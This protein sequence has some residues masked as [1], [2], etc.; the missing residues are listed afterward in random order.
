MPNDHA[1]YSRVSVSI[2]RSIPAGLLG[3]LDDG[4]RA[5][6]RNREIAWG[7]PLLVEDHIGQTREAVVVGYN[8]AYDQLELSLRLVEH[9]PWLDVAS[10]YQEN[11]QV[12]G[13]VVGLT[14]AGAFVELEPGIEGFLPA[15]ELPLEPPV[16][17]EDWLWIHDRLVALITELDADR[18]R[19]RLSLRR[20]LRRREAQ[21]HRQMWGGYPQVATVDVTVA[22]VLPPQVRQQ[23]LRLAPAREPLDLEPRVE[24]LLIEDDADYAAGLE[25]FLQGNGCHVTVTP[26]AMSGL[27]HV[28]SQA[29]P[30]DLI[31]VDWNLPGLKGHQVIQQLQQLGCA[32]RL[33]MVLEPAPLREYPEIR[34][35]LWQSGVDVFSKADGE[36]CRLG[37]ITILRELRRQE[38]D[39]R[40]SRQRS[41]PAMM[42]PTLDQP[43][44]LAGNEEQALPDRRTD[45]Q[46]I[47][48]A[49]LEDT[50]ATTALLL[51]L[52]P[53]HA[54][55]VLESSAGVAFPL[56]QA[57]PDLIYS[58]LN[59]VLHKGAEVWE[60]VPS[61][62]AKFK[63]LL[64]LLPFQGFLGIPLP[65]VH[66]ARHGLVL[67]K[68][69]GSFGRHHRQRARVAVYLLA[70][71]L[72]EQRLTRAL[73]P[74]QAQ[75]L[76]GQLLNSMIHEVTNKLG[77]LEYQTGILREGLRDLA[78]WPQKAQ[79]PTFLRTLEQ[80]AE[81]IADGQGRAGEL[82]NRYLGLT[83][84]DEPQSVDL[85][86]LVGE[87]IDVM[88]PEAQQHNI[89]LGLEAC[90]DLPPVWARPS[91]L[92]QI[93]LNLLLNAIQQMAALQRQGNLIV[94]LAYHPDGSLPLKVRF[95]DEGCGIHH[96]L[97]E[98]IFDF[99]FTTKKDGAGLGLTISRQAAA[100]LGGRLQVEESHVL[101]GT[102]FLLEL[103]ETATAAS[104]GPG[105]E[106]RPGSKKRSQP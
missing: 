7:A 73:R 20:L 64:D 71:I 91:Y 29:E 16:R 54:R 10:R 66:A 13:Q 101:W 79:D 32:S 33:A 90:G 8:P 84:G 27:A 45:L 38:P 86:A 95:Q 94:A 52:E 43:P 30:F 34:E 24:L 36:A 88:R 42:L 47:L 19:L 4:C 70:R 35:A 23:L 96:Q 17:I 50:R 56:D 26:E 87:M 80:A 48:D 103:P 61:D 55:P 63:R 89:M 41:F 22:E 65:A 93:F 68:E 76:V 97:W 18:R 53:G 44:A 102:T 105:P 99:G 15:A 51:R 83:A 39:P 57:P 5:I 60:R 2:T 37:L 12:S 1:L 59:D 98:H 31:L 6:I 104:P 100:S 75:N 74:W 69:Q 77:G 58:P 40:A 106:S 9:D 49:L 92:R 62:S 72:Q 46:V 85:Q 11:A 67:L 25:A 28:R 14:T 81:R 21:F 82:R 3:C 78:R